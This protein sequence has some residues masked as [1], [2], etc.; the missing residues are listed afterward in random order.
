[1]VVLGVG[2][3]MGM[4]NLEMEQLRLVAHRYKSL[5]YQE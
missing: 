3:T 4:A 5:E 2:V 1:M